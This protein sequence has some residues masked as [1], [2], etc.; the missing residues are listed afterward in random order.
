M[1]I[2]MVKVDI[3]TNATCLFRLLLVGNVGLKIVQRHKGN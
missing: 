1:A 3:T 2:R